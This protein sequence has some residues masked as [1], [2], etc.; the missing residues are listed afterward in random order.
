MPPRRMS[1][2]TEDMS[3]WLDRKTYLLGYSVIFC[4]YC[5]FHN[6]ESDGSLIFKSDEHYTYLGDQL[7]ICGEIILVTDT[8]M[9]KKKKETL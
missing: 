6:P 8:E 9:T 1:Q 5:Y 4:Q 7:V 3:D 2:T